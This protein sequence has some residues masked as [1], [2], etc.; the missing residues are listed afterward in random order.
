MSRLREMGVSGPS[1]DASSA[2]PSTVSGTA[3]EELSTEALGSLSH[4]LNNALSVILTSSTS[5][6]RREPAD[7]TTRRQLELVRRSAL[8]IHALSEELNDALAVDSGQLEL[9]LAAL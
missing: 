6:L 8:R 7:P 9:K 4:D 1:K 2:A 5:L 3:R